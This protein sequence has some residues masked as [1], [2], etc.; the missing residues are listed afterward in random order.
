MSIAQKVDNKINNWPDF[1][2]F[3]LQDFEEYQAN[4]KAVSEALSRQVK[5]EQIVRFAKGRFYKPKNTRFGQVRPGQDAF[6]EAFLYRIRKNRKEPI[7]YITGVSL[8]Y[9]W[10]LTTQI[11]AQIQLVSTEGSFDKNIS[12]IRITAKKTNIDKLTEDRILVLQ[13]LDVMKSF[14]VIPDANPARTIRLLQKYV[15]TFDSKSIREAEYFAQKYYRP[16]VQALL[17]AL[18]ENSLGYSSKKLRDALSPFSQYKIGI[19][20]G[21]IAEA[22]SWRLY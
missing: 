15:S 9:E 5:Q 7:A 8:F 22:E 14:S 20:S 19:D 6:I 3:R 4:P 16:S 10:G 13:I 21:L 12:G 17:G 1:K 11:P 2:V 18:L